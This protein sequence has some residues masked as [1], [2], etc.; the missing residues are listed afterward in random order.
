MKRN[1]IVIIG[2]TITVLFFCGCVETN[3]RGSYIKTGA[4]THIRYDVVFGGTFTDYRDELYFNDGT[5]LMVKY[6]SDL[7][8][9][10]LNRTGVFYFEKNYFNYDG[11]EY[12]F[13]KLNKVIYDDIN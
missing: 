4:V 6:D 11:R 1:L 12:R 5:M 7:S 13:H 9:I 2:L 10:Q 8:S 3:E